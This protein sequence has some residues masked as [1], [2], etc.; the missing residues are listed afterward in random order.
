MPTPTVTITLE[1]PDAEDL[2]HRL[3]VDPRNDR[4]T[5]ALRAALDEAPAVE[6]IAVEPA[7]SKAEG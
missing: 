1:R 3:F 5:D 7:Q 2:L 6:A 4:I